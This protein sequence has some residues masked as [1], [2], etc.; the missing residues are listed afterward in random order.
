MMNVEMDTMNRN[1]KKF[2]AGKL[3]LSGFTELQDVPQ[4]DYILCTA[5]NGVKVC[6]YCCYSER[7]I[8]SDAI[9]D[10]AEAKKAFQ[11]RA[12]MIIT[13]AF[14][15]DFAKEIAAEKKIAVKESVCMTTN[16]PSQH[17]RNKGWQPTPNAKPAKKQTPFRKVWFWCFIA[18]VLICG[19]QYFPHE[20]STTTP[21]EERIVIES[22]Y[23][24]SNHYKIDKETLYKNGDLFLY[25]DILTVI[26][27]SDIE[28]TNGVAVI[29]AHPTNEFGAFNAFAFNFSS[30]AADCVKAGDVLTIAATVSVRHDNKNMGFGFCHIVGLGEIKHELTTESSKKIVQTL[31][32]Q[33]K[34]EDKR[35]AEENAKKEQERQEA[36]KRKAEEERQDFCASC[37]IL[38]YKSV[39]RNPQD[40]IN[41]KA[42][43]TGTVIQVQEYELTATY[44]SVVL[45]VDCDG[46]IWYVT[47]T[48]QGSGNRILED[49]VITCYG[50]C[51]GI[52]TYTALLGNQITIPKLDMLY[53]D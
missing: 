44:T 35:I 20:N 10:V 31:S 49:D 48:R 14:L 26:T 7:S 9:S 27:V 28:K 32:E 2:I 47:Y 45:R 36:E 29:R 25:K 50:R 13:N 42:K 5:K 1:Y 24:T 6:V 30:T 4:T 19:Y 39:M 11:C 38:D 23:D 37:E 15:D 34:A 33:K 52:E 40:F 53:Y 41:T 3:Q 16:T 51:K 46:D 22:D 43:I 18:L 8:D 21:A 12:A 17:T